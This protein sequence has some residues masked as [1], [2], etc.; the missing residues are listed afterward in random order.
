MAGPRLHT[1]LRRLIVVDDLLVRPYYNLTFAVVAYR[2]KVAAVIE[3]VIGSLKHPG[4]WVEDLA[5]LPCKESWEFCLRLSRSEEAWARSIGVANIQAIAEGYWADGRPPKSA[6]PSDAKIVA[7]KV[8]AAAL[9]DP[10]QQVRV[11]AVGA[12]DWSSQ[13]EKIRAFANDPSP[14]VREQVANQISDLPTEIRTELI[15][16]LAGDSS[17]SVQEVVARVVGQGD[18]AGLEEPARKALSSPLARDRS[19]AA[20]VLAGLGH[21][22]EVLPLLKDRDPHVRASAVLSIGGHDDMDVE[23]ILPLCG[24]EDSRVVQIALERVSSRYDLYEEQLKMLT[25][26]LALAKPQHAPLVQREIERVKRQMAN[27]DDN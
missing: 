14:G 23:H 9:S 13:P 25:K 7:K 10:N 6:V 3:P 11:A 26:A 2:E 18:D 8:V 5:Y 22:K 24:D 4:Q 12:H 19:A 15:W 17:L 1:L 16:K 20:L 27:D 21:D